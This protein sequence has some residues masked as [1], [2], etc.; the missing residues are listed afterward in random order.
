MASQRE[1]P[2]LSISPTGQPAASEMDPLLTVT[3]IASILRLK[4]KQ[5]YGL[6]IPCIRVSR[7]AMRFRQS[8]FDAW[9][10]A[11]TGKS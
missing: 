5:V 3:D 8:A 11:R 7:R 6:K 2:K 9:L 4:P 10:A 1:T